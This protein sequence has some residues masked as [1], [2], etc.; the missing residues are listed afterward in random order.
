MTL[1]AG[2]ATTSA[3]LAC[4]QRK[5]T[6]SEAPFAYPTTTPLLLMAVAVL[7][8]V[9]G[10]TPRLKMSPPAAAACAAG[11]SQHAQT[12]SSPHRELPV[13]FMRFP[14]RFEAAA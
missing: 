8:V 9:F 4:V 3:P 14:A 2:R 5:P 13:L 1:H 12:R 6:T 11:Q 10:I 7:V